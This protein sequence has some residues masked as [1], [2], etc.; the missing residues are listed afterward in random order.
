MV[1]V[2]VKDKEYY[3]DGILKKNLDNAKKIIR[4]DWDYVFV[5]EGPCIGYGVWSI[6]GCSNCCCSIFKTQSLFDI[7]SFVPEV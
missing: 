4:K 6:K 1:K 3:M 7:S 5:I 2:K